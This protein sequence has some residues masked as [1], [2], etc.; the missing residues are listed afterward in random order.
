[1]HV[2]GSHT[3]FKVVGRF[4]GPRFTDVKYYKSDYKIR[5][6]P[7]Q[8][9]NKTRIAASQKIRKVAADISAIEL[10]VVK[11]FDHISQKFEGGLRKDLVRTTNF[12]KL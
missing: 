1:V 5:G 6:H 11:K 8:K 3:H 12:G 7:L 2:R 4:V 9:I 10:F